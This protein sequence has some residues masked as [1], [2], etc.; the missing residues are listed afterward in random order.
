MKKILLGFILGLS[1]LGTTAQALSTFNIFQGGT[2]NSATPSTNA[3]IYFDGTKYTG[4]SS[5]PLYVGGINASSTGVAGQSVFQNFTFVSGTG[6]SAT[7]T[8]LFTT[9]ASTTNFFGAMLSGCNSASN[10]LTW[11]NGLFGCNTA[12]TGASSTLLGDNNTWTGINRFQTISFTLATGTQATTTLSFFSPNILGSL[13]QFTTLN[14]T[15][16]GVAN[17]S[18]FKNFTAVNSTSTQ[19]TTSALAVTNLASALMLTNA[20]GGVIPYGGVT[21][22]NQLIRALSAAGASTCATVANTDLANSAITINGTSVSL[23]GTITVASTTLLA[24]NNTWTGINNFATISWTNGTGTQ[25]TTTTS[26]F[27]PSVFG[28]TG[29]FTTLI[30]TGTGVANQST[31]KNFTFVIATG[32]DATTTNSFFALLNTGSTG[33]FNVVVATSTTA[34]STFAAAITVGAGQGTSTFGGGVSATSFSQ[35]A[36]STGSKGW[37]IT[38]GCFSINGTCVGAGSTLSVGGTGAIQFANGTAFNGDASRFFWD[39]TAK[40]IALGTTTAFSKLTLQGIFGEQANLLDIASSTNSNNSATTSLFRVAATGRVLIGT[41]TSSMFSAT[42]PAMVTIDPGTNSSEEGLDLFG[43]TNDFYELNVMNTSS[44]ASA[45]SCLTATGNGGNLT[46]NFLSGCVNSSAFNNPQIYNAGFAGDSNLISLAKNMYLMQ[47]T[48]GKSFYFGNGGVA[49]SSIIMTLASSTANSLVG[50]VGIGT[51]SPYSMLSVAGQGVFQNLIATGTGALYQSVFQ[52]FTFVNG[53]GTNATTTAFNTTN[54]S[55]GTTTAVANGIVANGSIRSAEKNVATSSSIT[56][57]WSLAN[58]Q[59]V[60]LGGGAVTITFINA[61]STGVA[62]SI[63]INGSTLRLILCNPG[64]TAGAVTYSFPSGALLWSGGT[65]PVQTTTANK[66]DIVSFIT[67]AGTST[68]IMMGAA[69][70]NY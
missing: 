52:N 69:S 32:T 56:V 53:T 42:H 4:T 50:A 67:S 60:R 65:A 24:N 11:N 15:G 30:A 61:T 31:F 10:A 59:L 66:C 49:T 18:T 26:F 34:T 13:G 51:T 29:Q 25:A 39:N 46:S 9:T 35:T 38:A 57:D 21:C 27:S 2:N 68:P 47:G 40:N 12:I 55:V 54:L 1:L 48:N 63:G 20:T 58:Q 19:A 22:T 37:D 41:T 16:T 70:L 36:T 5:N 43:N 23:G 28:S 7:T 62:N 8:N 14:A 44:G 33:R 45:Q 3:L 17:Q 64:V 6:T